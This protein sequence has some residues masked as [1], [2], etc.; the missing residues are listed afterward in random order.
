MNLEWSDVTHDLQF[1]T[2]RNTKNGETLGFPLNTKAQIYLKKL[3]IY[4]CHQL[5]MYSAHQKV[6]TT[7]VA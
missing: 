7:T 3:E 2:C 6:N 5:N 4:E 1:I